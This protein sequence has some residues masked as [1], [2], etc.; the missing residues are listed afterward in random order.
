MPAFSLRLVLTWLRPGASQDF[1]FVLDQASSQLEG[2]IEAARLGRSEN[3]GADLA[4]ARRGL[5]IAGQQLLEIAQVAL[6]AFG[7][8]VGAL[9]GEIDST[10]RRDRIVGGQHVFGAKDRGLVLD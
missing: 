6:L 10:S 7:K 8:Q 1:S 4:G 9:Q 3:V 5:Q 2:A